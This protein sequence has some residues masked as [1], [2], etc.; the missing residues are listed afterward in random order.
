MKTVAYPLL[1]LLLASSSLTQAAEPR[2]TITDYF[3]LLPPDTLEGPPA[4]WLTFLRQPG[5]GRVDTANGYISCTGDGAQ[6]S[7]DVALFATPMSTLSWLSAPESWKAQ[8]L[9]SSLFINRVRTARCIPPPLH[10]SDQEFQEHPLRPAPQR[11]YRHRARRQ[12]RQD[13][14]SPDLERRE[15]Y[16]GKISPCP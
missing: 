4:G 5:C 16:R 14:P 9:C 3:L 7:F 6:P 15:V 12:V 10:L 11:A 1:G 8:T 2:K 13:H